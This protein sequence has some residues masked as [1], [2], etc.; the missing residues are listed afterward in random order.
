MKKA[1]NPTGCGFLCS[2]M[3]PE[4]RLKRSGFGRF[5]GGYIMPSIFGNQVDRPGQ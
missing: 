5:Q 3:D 4:L 2:G 1:A